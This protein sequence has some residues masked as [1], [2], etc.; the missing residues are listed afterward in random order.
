MEAISVSVAEPDVPLP[1]GFEIDPVAGFPDYEGVAAM[2]DLGLPG[3]PE[4]PEL[5]Q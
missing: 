2:S 5:Q 3:L 1:L 4:L